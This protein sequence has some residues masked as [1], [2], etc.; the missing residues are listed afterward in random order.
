M[1]Q[2]SPP[3]RKIYKYGLVCIKDNK[4]L[5]CEPLGFSDLILPGGLIEGDEKPADN[6]AREVAEELGENARLDFSSLKYIGQFED[7]AAGKIVANVVIELWYGN[8]AGVLIA[9]SEIKS[10]HWF[11]PRGDWNKLSPII[12]NKILPK[13]ISIG[14]L[15]S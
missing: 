12:R 1:D 8:I 2:P 10:L 5:L 11:D 14:Y 7:R 13:L 4:I 9:S 6:F 3:I 15:K